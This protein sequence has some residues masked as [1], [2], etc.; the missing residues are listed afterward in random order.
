M[1]SAYLILTDSGGV[2]E[3]AP[4]LG[5]PVLVLR[6]DTER[7]EAVTEGVVR[8]IGTETIDIV[9]EASQLL[10]DKVA[11]DKMAIGASPYGDGNASKRIVEIV[12]NYFNSKQI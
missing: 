7:P 3:E 1:K 5:K 11:Y 12:R 2:Q 6:R 9:R 4:A 10:S 8:L